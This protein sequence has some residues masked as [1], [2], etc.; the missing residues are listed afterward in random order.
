MVISASFTASLSCLS[1]HC[2]WQRPA[3]SSQ[4]AFPN[5]ISLTFELELRATYT[6][7]IRGEGYPFFDRSGICKYCL[8]LTL[9]I[10]VVSWGVINL[11]S[12]NSQRETSIPEGP[13]Y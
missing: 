2:V 8:N 3:G 12:P 5:K 9:L 4:R 10:L 11:N 13:K 6:N 1:K 7:P